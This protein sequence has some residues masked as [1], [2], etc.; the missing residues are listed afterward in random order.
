MWLVEYVGS[1]MANGKASRPSLIWR[2]EMGWGL[3]KDKQKNASDGMVI[4]W[5]T[6]EGATTWNIHEQNKQSYLCWFPNSRWTFLLG[7]GVSCASC[8]SVC[9]M[10]VCD[11]LS[12]LE[13]KLFSRKQPT[14]SSGLAPHAH[15]ELWLVGGGKG[16]E[17]RDFKVGN[18]QGCE[19]AEQTE[20]QSHLE[21]VCA[22]SSAT[23]RLV[24]SREE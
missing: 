20:S 23:W 15:C 16:Q 9:V 8:L 3:L 21:S 24:F 2:M 14:A 12:S 1:K 7:L 13:S 4:K 18:I 19:A 6:Q 10:D 17:L 22:C 5:W 11:F